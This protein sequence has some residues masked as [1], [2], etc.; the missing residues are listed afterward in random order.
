MTAKTNTFSSPSPHLL[1][2]C[3]VTTHKH[4]TRKVNKQRV[5]AA[6]VF[7][8]QCPQTVPDT[9]V[10]SRRSINHDLLHCNLPAIFSRLQATI[11]TRSTTTVTRKPISS[12]RH[13][14]NFNHF[15]KAIRF[16]FFVFHSY[17]QRSCKMSSTAIFKES[18]ISK[19]TDFGE[20][21]KKYVAAPDLVT[22]PQLQSFCSVDFLKY[23]VSHGEGVTELLDEFTKK[24]MLTP[25]ELNQ[26]MRALGDDSKSWGTMSFNDLIVKRLQSQQAPKNNGANNSGNSD[27]NPSS[28]SI[29]NHSGSSNNNNNIPDRS[30]C[31]F[32]NDNERRSQAHTRNR[33]CSSSNSEA[34][35]SNNSNDLNKVCDCCY[36]EVFGCGMTSVAPTSRNFDEMRERLRNRLSKKKGKNKSD[37]SSDGT[38]CLESQPTFGNVKLTDSS[39]DATIKESLNSPSLAMT[40][41]LT[42]PC[43]DLTNSN[44]DELLSFV[45]GDQK[46]NELKKSKRKER[47]KRKEKKTALTD[48]S[49][50][51]TLNDLDTNGF[52]S[53]SDK[54]DSDHED[55]LD[56]LSSS[57]T[58]NPF[59][60]KSSNEDDDK[61]SDCSLHRQRFDSSS[62][63]NCRAWLECLICF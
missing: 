7:F 33:T 22:L 63:G 48:D 27:N 24:I 40:K 31:K 35:P 21:M 13:Q 52:D 59:D 10:P 49:L 5:L 36:C 58:G 12:N 29:S 43:K 51:S 26:F 11:S 6:F 23:I 60:S 19:Q 17:R 32:A 53:K 46:G 44:I 38:L 18:S 39:E 41:E 14:I 9:V 42:V 37:K 25:N 20:L 62:S 3:I 15:E 30:L 56:R 1:A 54:Y 57:F 8:L 4:V 28:N 16:V 61:H 55:S 47:R 50:K 2:S 45:N 34:T